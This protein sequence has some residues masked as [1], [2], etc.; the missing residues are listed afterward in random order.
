[1]PAKHII[2]YFVISTNGVVNTKM[3]LNCDRHLL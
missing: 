2:I 3:Y 1:M